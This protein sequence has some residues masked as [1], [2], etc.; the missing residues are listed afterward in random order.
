MQLRKCPDEPELE[1][2]EDNG[3]IAT[4]WLPTSTRNEHC[5]VCGKLYKIEIDAIM[6]QLH[7]HGYVVV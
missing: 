4:P 3:G 5:G 6:Q 1:M 2:V 7:K